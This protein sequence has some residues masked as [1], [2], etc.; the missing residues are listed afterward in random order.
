MIYEFGKLNI[1]FQT[2]PWQ[3]FPVKSMEQPQTYPS[4]FFSSSTQTPLFKQGDG[5]QWD[6]VMEILVVK[7]KTPYLLINIKDKRIFESLCR[8]LLHLQSLLYLVWNKLFVQNIVCWILVALL[9]LVMG[10]MRLP[11]G[12]S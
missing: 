11:W 5:S 3:R 12:S 7:N 2:L 10:E 6:A 4:I 9:L 1:Y 8:K